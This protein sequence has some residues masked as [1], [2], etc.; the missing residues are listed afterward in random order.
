MD[1]IIAA[2][3]GELAAVRAAMKDVTEHSGA[4][5]SVARGTLYGRPVVVARSGVG[6]V[7]AAMC[8][9]EIIST[10]QPERIIL[11]GIAGALHEQLSIGDTVLGAD[12]LQYDMN[13]TALGFAVG[14]VPYTPYRF[15]HSDP[16]ML[17]TASTVDSSLGAVLH[18]RILSGDRFVSNIGESDPAL[19]CLLQEDLSGDVVEMEGAA[20]AFVAT[21]NCIPFL[22]IRTISDHVTAKPSIRLKQFLRQTSQNNL[23]FV[24]ALLDAPV[25]A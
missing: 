6:K 25:P 12:V 16:A 18:G 15:L 9:Q 7:M 2:M 5:G 22:I 14:E 1:A 20:L 13:A 21:V 17:A 10:Y 4:V 3:D 19:L 8:A 23:R 24:A 11:I